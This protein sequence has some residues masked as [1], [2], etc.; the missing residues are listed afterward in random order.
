MLAV[1]ESPLNWPCLHTLIFFGAQLAAYNYSIHFNWI[2]LG[3]NRRICVAFARWIWPPNWRSCS[4]SVW[5]NSSRP[6]ARETASR[7]AEPL[8]TQLPLPLHTNTSIGCKSTMVGC[9]L[10][11]N[12]YISLPF[13][14]LNEISQWCHLQACRSDQFGLRIEKGQRCLFM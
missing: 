9:L 7:P 4:R 1:R 8:S 5:R 3:L 10:E 2:V 12:V 11:C 14:F 13:E 6:P